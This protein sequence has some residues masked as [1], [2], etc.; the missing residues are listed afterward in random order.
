MEWQGERNAKNVAWKS[1]AASIDLSPHLQAMV[2]KLVD[3]NF[4]AYYPLKS[5]ERW[6][7]LRLETMGA[8]VVFAAGCLSVWSAQSMYVGVAALVL[9][10]ASS[11]TGILAFTVSE[12][13]PTYPP[14]FEPDPESGPAVHDG[15]IR[16]VSGA[17]VCGSNGS[18]MD[19]ATAQMNYTLARRAA[20]L[21]AFNRGSPIE[22]SQL[23]RRPTTTS[24]H[25][26]DARGSQGPLWR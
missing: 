23:K 13:A 22:C 8:V 3:Q 7:G 24:P 5:L 14:L 11:L 6:I 20:F 15:C 25:A 1:D 21:S 26:N 18:I 12:D 17:A 2:A 9:Y 10:R 16:E 4:Q 19:H